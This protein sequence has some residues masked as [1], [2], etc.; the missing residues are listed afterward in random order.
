MSSLGENQFFI[1]AEKNS[2]KQQ[3]NCESKETY[4]PSDITGSIKNNVIESEWKDIGWKKISGIYKIVNK[5]NG[6]YYVGSSNH[7][8]CRWSG[9]KSALNKQKHRNDYLQKAWN[10]HGENAFEFLIVESDILEHNLSLVEQKYLDTAKQE[11]D[12][13]YNLNF[14]ADRVEMT[15]EIRKKL[16][17]AATGRK[18]TRRGVKLSDETKRLLSIAH[19]GKMPPAET[20]RKAREASIN[21]TVYRFQNTATGEIFTGNANEFRKTHVNINRSSIWRLVHNQIASHKSWIVL[22]PSPTTA[23]AGPLLRK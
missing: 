7:L 9:H 6:K 14:L 22:P 5:H 11:R 15:P 20:M 12:K 3:T 4:V 23:S 1:W 18:G 10:K 16:S 13:C 2:T 8:Y 17:I 19:K 21:H